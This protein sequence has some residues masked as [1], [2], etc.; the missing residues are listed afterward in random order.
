MIHTDAHLT[1]NTFVQASRHPLVLNIET[2]YDTLAV[3][4]GELSEEA[5]AAK[6][7][8]FRKALDFIEAE[9]AKR[10]AA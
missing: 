2:G 6:I 3:Y 7:S 8:D 4:F 10:V 1:Q 9:A 5:L